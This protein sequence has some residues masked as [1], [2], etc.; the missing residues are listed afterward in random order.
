[1]NTH[2]LPKFGNV[3]IESITALD[4]ETF[5]SELTCGSKTKTNILTPFR[6]VMVFAK[7][8]KYIESNPFVDVDP[9]KKTKSKEKRAL[10]IEGVR[11]FM[12]ELDVFWKPLFIFLF[13]V[14]V[15]IAEAAALKWKRVIFQ[16]GTIRIER[17]LVRIKGGIH[18][19]KEP[20]NPE[21]FREI[22]APA[23]V[24][25]MLQEQRKR[26]WKGDGDD[27]VF[28]NRR[29]R[30]I[31][32]HTLNNCVINPILKKLG[33][34]HISIKNTRASFITNALDEKERISFIQ[35]YVGHSTPRMIVDHYYRETQAPDDG[36]NLENAWNSTRILPESDGSCLEVIENT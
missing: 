19:Y 5:I 24:M 2:V 33:Y 9:I 15:R 4:I 35:K 27:F 28:L 10:S 22:K 25:D 14:G 12:D 23:F 16:T 6:A 11:H 8:H 21:S 36:S 20:K 31:H 32:R 3:P 29:G 30:P 1:M 34:E 26:T 17:N 7:K 18:I 13:F